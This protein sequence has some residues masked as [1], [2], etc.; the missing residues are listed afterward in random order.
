MSYRKNHVMLEDGIIYYNQAGNQDRNTAQNTLSVIRF[1]ADGLPEVKL[2]V[3]YTASDQM[4]EAAIQEGYYALQVLPI[5][6]AAIVGA[7][8]HMVKLVTEMAEAAGKS[9]VIHFANSRAAAIAWLK[10]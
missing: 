5:D 8:P 9:Q 10:Q 7:S 3:D 1:L 2:L 4:D 6:K